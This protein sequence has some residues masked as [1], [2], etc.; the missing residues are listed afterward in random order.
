M[1]TA[2]IPTVLTVSSNGTAPVP[3]PGPTTSDISA[4]VMLV[5]P[6]MASD[7]LRQ[8]P[9]NRPINKGHVR[10]LI[11]TIRAGAWRVN[12]ESIVLGPNLEVLDGQHRLLAIAESGHSVECLIA[13]GVPVSSMVTIDQC[14]P[15]SL[16]DTAATQGLPQSRTLAALCTWIQRYETHGMRQVRCRI[17]NADLRDFLAA[18]AGLEAALPWARKLAPLLPGSLAAGLY[19][20]ASQRDGPL[21]TTFFGS[22]ST[23]LGLQASHPG[24]VARQRLI[25]DRAARVTHM[26]AV[27]KGALVVL[28]WNCTREG[29]SMPHGMVWKGVTDSTVPFPELL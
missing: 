2:L 3:V 21:A 14:R 12:G 6:Q 26:Q 19:W 16:A 9:S 24:Y 28:A 23:G 22:L 7:L 29:R 4:T 10:T 17:P 13:V 18:H 27:E 11:A 15:R 1:A 20:L 8:R 25:K 5:T